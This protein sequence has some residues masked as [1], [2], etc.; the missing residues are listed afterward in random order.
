MRPLPPH[1]SQIRIGADEYRI[2]ILRMAR[3]T[4]SMHVGQGELFV[5]APLH[6]NLKTILDWV[7]T[8][9]SWIGKRTAIIKRMKLEDDEVWYLGKKV[10]VTPSN[11]TIFSIGGMTLKK[12][13]SLDAAMRNRAI[14]I[15]TIY[16]N[17]AA[18]ELGYGPQELKFRT[19][20]RSWG[21]CTS[22]GT[23]TLNTHLI[24]CDPRFIRYVCIHE[25]VHLK[26]LDHS[27]LFWNE[28]KHHV[29]DLSAVKKLSVMINKVDR[30]EL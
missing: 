6:S 3:R 12:G 9:Q 7:A 15:L 25:L 2:T 18:Y 23:I 21:R 10:K 29:P 17:H 30:F 24:A 26:Y 19:M 8:K 16:F 11:H 22:K 20:T 13:A 5:K 4:L 27:P 1:T 28:V 14:D